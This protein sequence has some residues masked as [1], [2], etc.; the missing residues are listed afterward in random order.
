MPI[1]YQSLEINTCQ[2]II[3]TTNILTYFYE[4]INKS[5][6]WHIYLI[7]HPQNNVL[8]LTA[9]NSTLLIALNFLS[10]I[11]SLMINIKKVTFSTVLKSTLL[12]KNHN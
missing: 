4:Q 5:I 7:K 12:E 11:I 8:L 9:Y 3:T 2:N 6:W 1:Q 10:V